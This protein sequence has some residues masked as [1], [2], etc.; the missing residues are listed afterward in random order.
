MSEE[1]GVETLNPMT[2]ELIET[3][4]VEIMKY[5]PKNPVSLYLG[6]VFERVGVVA[7]T[8]AMS[9]VVPEHLQDKPADCFLVAA[10]AFRWG[11]DPFAVAQGCYVARGRVGYEG[12]IIAALINARLGKK[13]DYEYFG[14]EGSEDR[15]VKVTGTIKGEDKPRSISGEFS[16]WATRN[17]AGTDWSAQWK[18]GV[19]QMLAYRGAREW[20]RRYMPEAVLGLYSIDE[21]EEMEREEATETMGAEVVDAVLDGVVTTQ[22]DPPERVRAN[23]APEKPQEEAQEPAQEPEEAQADPEPPKAPKKAS[24]ARKG[25]AAKKPAKK[26]KPAPEPEPEP[27]PEPEPEPEPEPRE[28]ASEMSE[29][30]EIDALFS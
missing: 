22:D 8:M 11:M 12:K 2:G 16:K 9:R 4:P 5:D 24:G 3:K 21:V 29:E 25:P 18:K 17:K 15:G 27:A 19:D 20:A 13:L 28:E 14:K 1:K 30:D 6:P 10:Q 7:K 23:K 26:A